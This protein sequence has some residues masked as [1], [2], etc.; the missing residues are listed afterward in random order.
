MVAPSFYATAQFFC[1]AP[2]VHLFGAHLL[3]VFAY[4]EV[5]AQ[6]GDR[7]ERRA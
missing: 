6:G 4:S 7:T 3:T 2:N 1:F 5:E